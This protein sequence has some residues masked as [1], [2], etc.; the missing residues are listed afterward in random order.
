LSVVGLLVALA[1]L[2][3]NLRPVTFAAVMLAVL[4]ALV[5]FE[6]SA[7]PLTPHAPEGAEWWVLGRLGTQG[8]SRVS[9]QIC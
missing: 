6:I 7:P 2:G 3:A 9:V 4:V 8:T 5:S 1:F